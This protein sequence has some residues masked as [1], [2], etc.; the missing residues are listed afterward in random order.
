A[1]VG[2]ACPPQAPQHVWIAPLALAAAGEQ[3]SAHQLA[4]P[5][6]LAQRRRRVRAV[7]TGELSGGEGHVGARVAA[8]EGHH[9]VWQVCQ[10]RL[11]EPRRRR[12]AERIAVERR[13]LRRDPP[14]LAGDPNAG[15]TALALE[16]LQHRVGRVALGHPLGAL[17]GGQVAEAAEDLLEGVAI[18]CA[19]DLGA[20]LK[21]V[22]HLDQ[23]LW[24]DEL[25]Q[26]L[27]AEQ[28]AKQ[29]TVQRQRRRTPLG[30]RRIAL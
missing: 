28:L 25:S 4:V 15:G 10:E 12:H 29:L 30:V 13:I 17:G 8:N 9:R 6:Q 26:L 7:A 20:V 24:V 19:C 11:R 16:L 27:L 1:Q 3:L 5:L 18:L 21:R 2:Q 23:R 14:L 22:L